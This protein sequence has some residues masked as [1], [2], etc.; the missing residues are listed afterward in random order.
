M[1]DSNPLYELIGGYYPGEPIPRKRPSGNFPDQVEFN[2]DQAIDAYLRALDKEFDKYGVS[3]QLKKYFIDDVARAMQAQVRPKGATYDPFRAIEIGDEE[4][5]AGVQLKIDVNPV[6][7]LRDPVT[8]AKDTAAQWAK[9]FA[10]WKDFDTYMELSELWNPLLEGS[11]SNAAS[12]AY[13]PE[14]VDTYAPG[15]QPFQLLN[16]DT[17]Y[18][19]KKKKLLTDHDDKIIEIEDDADLF[20]DTAGE[21][22]KF[23]RNVRSTGTR[24]SPFRDLASSAAFASASE[25]KEALDSG[26]IKDARH[27]KI[28][29]SYLERAR[30]LRIANNLMG[31]GDPT[32]YVFNHDQ[33][34]QDDEKKAGKTNYGQSIG[35]GFGKISE[36]LSKYTLGAETQDK[37][38]EALEKVLKGGLNKNTGKFEPST[39][40]KTRV[41]LQEADDWFK[42]LGKTDYQEFFK[43]TKPLR[44]LLDRFEELKDKKITNETD[45]RWFKGQVDYILESFAREGPIKG[46]LHNMSR[47]FVETNFLNGDIKEV[48]MENKEIVGSKNLLNVMDGALRTYK[49]EDFNDF[50]DKLETQGVLGVVGDQFWNLFRKRLNGFTPA[51]LVQENLKRVHYFGMKYDPKYSIEAG[52]NG[53]YYG[54][55]PKSFMRPLNFIVKPI[56]KAVNGMMEKG[57]LKGLFTNTQTHDL[58]GIGRFKFTGNANLRLG[59]DLHG[60]TY[61]FDKETGNYLKKKAKAFVLSE[62]QFIGL[63]NGDTSLG[64]KYSK[65]FN[66]G[67]NKV[68]QLKDRA[69]ALRKWLQEHN[70][71]L[72]LTFS[73]GLIANTAENKRI[74]KQLF[75][76]LNRLEGNTVSFL[77]SKAGILDKLSQKFNRFQSKLFSKFKFLAP[78]AY[79]RNAIARAGGRLASRAISS[80]VAKLTGAAITAGSSGIAAVIYPLIEKTVQYLINKTLDFAGATLKTIREAS[81]DAVEE[82]VEKGTAALIKIAGIFAL[83]YSI[84]LII[85][86]MFILIVSLLAS[87]TPVDPTRMAAGEDFGGGPSAGPPQVCPPNECEVTSTVGCFQFLEGWD[88]GQGPQAL[89]IIQN[90]ANYLSGHAGRYVDRLCAGGPVE[91]VWNRGVSCGWT[92]SRDRIEFGDGQCWAYTASNQNLFNY[93]FAHESGHIYSIRNGLGA[94]GTAQSNDGGRTLPT[95]VGP[96]GNQC[97]THNNQDEDFAETVGQYV[98]LSGRCTDVSPSEFWH[99]YDRYC[100]TCFQGH[101]DFATSSFLFGP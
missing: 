46:P 62:N 22:K 44:D 61:K 97:S 98:T 79:G 83:A 93:L 55:D 94:L 27:Q 63:L 99:S 57:P 49:R 29:K 60:R 48:I 92:S 52:I 34:L 71:Q 28:A 32:N 35:D 4:D 86:V 80:I 66:E 91:V 17:N 88:S 19:I 37:A 30:V 45:A 31:K 82:F 77:Q 95:Y 38:Q 42:G 36:S 21:F 12:A 15:T 74:L 25:I 40:A 33:D 47:K 43:D 73:G 64:G 59:F 9:D 10:N 56:N 81:F 78:I 3:A 76:E 18:Q 11:L 101:Y 24:A 5:V 7:W 16:L 53:E 8:M 1:P 72:G 90:A 13:G 23:I 39:L 67:W 70:D 65:Y 41:A 20:Y 6:N 85:P 51:E 68:D 69:A 2:T 84:S 96:T 58:K 89:S 75:G 14:L 50:V 87:I 100:P 26:A 54:T